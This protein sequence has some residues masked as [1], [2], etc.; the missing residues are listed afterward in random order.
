MSYLINK[1]DFNLR[2]VGQKLIRQASSSSRQRSHKA[3]SAHEHGGGG[4]GGGGNVEKNR[5]SESSQQQVPMSAHKVHKQLSNASS[6]QSRQTTGQQYQRPPTPLPQQVSSAT[7]ISSGGGKSPLRTKCANQTLPSFL[8]TPSPTPVTTASQSSTT[9]KSKSPAATH[10]S[11]VASP[12]QTSTP[13]LRG[14][15]NR[16]LTKFSNENQHEVDTEEELRHMEATGG[17]SCVRSAAK[18]F[19]KEAASA[20]KTGRNLT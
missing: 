19:E 4:G 2:S 8:I 14:S 11:M 10:K 5:H 1:H 16:V 3:E 15:I 9:C 6:N 7:V 20:N 17:D 12:T 18:L 13:T